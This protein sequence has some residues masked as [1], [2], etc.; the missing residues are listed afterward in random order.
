MHVLKCLATLASVLVGT[1]A[2]AEP[3]K[4]ADVVEL[5][6]VGASNGNNWKNAVEL[7]VAEINAKGGILGRPIALTHYDTQT[8]PGTSRAQVQKALD[9][10]PYVLLGPIYSGS[11]KVNMVLAQRAQV[12]QIVGAQA[13]DLSAAGNKF[14]FRTN[15]N[16]DDGIVKV[17][18]YL[19]DTIQAKSVAMVWVNNDYG[20][21]GRDLHGRDEEARHRLC[22]RDLRRERPG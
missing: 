13:A 20:K 8:N 10:E 19:A 5:S 12:P 11:V 9:D 14:L 6:G 2:F 3:L 18:N 22:G 16:Q 17:A 1:A 4:I 15:L 21:G 7:A